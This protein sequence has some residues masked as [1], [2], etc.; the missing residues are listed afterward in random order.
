MT[1]AP[2]T[3]PMSRR[4]WLQLSL[5]TLMVLMLMFGCGFGWLSKNIRQFLQQQEELREL[6]NKSRLL[7][8]RFAAT[9]AGDFEIGGVELD[10]IRATIGLQGLTLPNTKATDAG[11]PELQKALSNLQIER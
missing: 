3:T 8:R 2:T 7:N 10:N 6:R 11:A 4:R 1:T 9:I 5:R